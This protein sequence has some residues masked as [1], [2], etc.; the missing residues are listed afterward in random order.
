MAEQNLSG[1]RVA[2]LTTHGFE[3]SELIEPR[4]AL[5]AAGASTR[6]VAPVSGQVQ[7]RHVSGRPYLG[8]GES[9]RL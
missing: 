2:I 7:G 3:Q 5:D 6:V 8:S 1:L 9:R 4:K